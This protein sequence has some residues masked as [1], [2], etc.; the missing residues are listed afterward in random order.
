[1]YT[2]FKV[3]REPRVPGNMR[4]IIDLSEEAKY[5]FPKEYNN[6]EEVIYNTMCCNQPTVMQIPGRRI[7]IDRTLIAP[8]LRRVPNVVRTKTTRRIG[9]D[10]SENN[11]MNQ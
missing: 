2:M 1:M 7:G 3:E 8:S 10:Q 9:L 4:R 11:V 6:S 5:I